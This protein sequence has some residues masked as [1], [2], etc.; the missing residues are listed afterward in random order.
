[1]ASV[2]S[3]WSLVL[4]AGSG[5]AAMEAMS[6]RRF[7]KADDCSSA[8]TACTAIAWPR[9]PSGWDPGGSRAR[10]GDRAY[11]PG[12]RGRRTDSDPTIDAVAVVHHETTTAC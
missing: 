2:D 11:R 9:S 7:A 12:G 1:V 10:G 8:G 3:D 6:V 4:I 5:T